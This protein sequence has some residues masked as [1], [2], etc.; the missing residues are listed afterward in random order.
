MSLIQQAVQQVSS[1]YFG[2][3]QS[4]VTAYTAWGRD[5]L[6]F[7]HVIFDKTF[8]VFLA[9]AVAVSLLYY[10]I[11]IYSAFSKK[12]HEEPVQECEWPF[13]TVQ[14]PTFNELAAL[15][16]AKNCLDFDYPKDKYEIIIGD[17]SNNPEIIQKI[18]EF[19]DANGII[20]TRRET[21][22]GFKPGNLNH[23][24]KFSKGDILVLFD[25]DFLPEKDFLK[26]LVYPM[27]KDKELAVVQARWKIINPN[28]NLITVLGATMS[29]VFHYLV[30]PFVQNF[31]K[32]SFLCGSAEA[33][34]KDVLVKVGGWQTG[35]LTEDIE[36]SLRLHSNGYKL[37][38][39]EDLE[40][41]C[42]VPYT[43]K[44]LY[45]QQMRWAYG[46]IKAFKTHFL[47][48]FGAKISAKKKLCVFIFAS[49]YF[50]SVLLMALFVFGTLS[51]ITHEPG[52]IDL[53]KFFGELGR[54]VL[55]TSGLLIA[56]IFVIFK[57]N[58]I[59]RVDK[60]IVSSLS[61][62]LVV[63]Y[64]VNIGILKV[65]FNQPMKWHMLKKKGNEVN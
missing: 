13:V 22:T 55:L 21:N 39:L 59:R 36:C 56:S 5:F 60:V 15:N 12:K 62:G 33:I 65:L 42:E 29:K 4:A 9:I 17:D 32:V 52:P 2:F 30:M 28:T 43:P 35:S 53:P 47:E 19:A 6:N 23:M 11:L 20:I 26:R 8:Y 37:K 41:S 64:F 61:Y 57:D 18:K 14:I 54:N 16:C 34:R 44:D 31:G 3:A 51:F 45:K 46:V 49:G 40:C 50:L 10:F 58:Q 63:T 38:Y 24:L 48:L 25:S 1:F 27:V 7:L